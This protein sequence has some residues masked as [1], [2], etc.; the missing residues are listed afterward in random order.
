MKYEKKLNHK[1]IHQI[2]NFIILYVN[3]FKNGDDWK[4]WGYFTLQI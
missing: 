2:L 3:N 1:Y 4:F